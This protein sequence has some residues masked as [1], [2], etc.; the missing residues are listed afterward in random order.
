MPNGTSGTVSYLNE[1]TGVIVPGGGVWALNEWGQV[2]LDALPTNILWTPNMEHGTVGVTTPILPLGQDYDTK[3]VGLNAYGQV[4][5]NSY[6]GSRV[7]HAFLWTPTT[8][9]GHSVNVT[10]LRTDGGDVTAL[11]DY[12]QVLGTANRKPLAYLWTPTAANAT[13]G[14]VTELAPLPGDDKVDYFKLTSAGAVVGTSFSFFGIGAWN[15][16]V[17][18]LPNGPHQTQGQLVPIGAVGSDSESWT[19]DM[20]AAGQLVGKSCT[21]NRL[22][23]PITCGRTSHAFVWDRAHGLHDLQDLLDDGTAFRLKDTIAIT[24]Q[25]QILAIGNDTSDQPH[26]LLLTPHR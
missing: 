2:L 7:A 17:V 8:P 20:N 18:W 4:I 15:R 25:G 3:L 11:N 6:S 13:S 24:D 9:H 22:G 10:V 1:G 5:A 12:G 26:L 21:L 19:S 16:S 23:Q 14:T